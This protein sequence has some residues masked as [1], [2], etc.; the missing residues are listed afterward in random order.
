M[1]MLSEFE[2]LVNEAIKIVELTCNHWIKRYQLHNYLAKEDIEDLKQDCVL[3]VLKVLKNFDPKK[4]NKLST[5][6]RPRID[7]TI[8]DFLSELNLE[9][10]IMSEIALNEIR[11]NLNML[12]MMSV[13]EV[14]IKVNAIGDTK[15]K[16]IIVDLGDQEIAH[17]IFDAML[18]LPESRRN[19]IF[20][21][22]LLEETIKEISEQHGFNPSSG[23][24]YQIKREGIKRLREILKERGVL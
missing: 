10:T 19:V 20:G 7:G 24:V 9:N 23:W 6:L 15:I 12:K 18:L 11:H 17:E 21:Y 13:E 22:Y 5:Y 3:A 2:I 16:E 8:K 14:A 1:K 4:E